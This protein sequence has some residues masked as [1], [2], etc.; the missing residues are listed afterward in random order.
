MLLIFINSYTYVAFSFLFCFITYI[1]TCSLQQTFKFLLLRLCQSEMAKKAINFLRVILTL[2]AEA[3]GKPQP[4][5]RY[6]K[7]LQ[8]NY[9]VK[10]I[11]W[12]DSIGH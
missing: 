7:S 4:P 5:L 3:E 10:S 8:E 11:F 12:T 6:G 2:Q 1:Y 9:E